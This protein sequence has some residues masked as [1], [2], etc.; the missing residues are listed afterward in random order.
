VAYPNSLVKGYLGATGQLTPEMRMKID[1]AVATGY[2]QLLTFEV[3]GGGFNWWVGSKSA[4]V[5]LTAYGVMEFADMERVLP[6]DRAVLDRASAFLFRTQA[7]DGTWDQVGENHG[8]RINHLPDPKTTLTAY[9]AWSLGESGY[10]GQPGTRRAVKFLE[11]RIADVKDTYALGLIVNALVANDSPEARR[12]VDELARRAKVEGETASWS[13]AATLSY[14]QGS[15]ADVETTALS[16]YALLRSKSQIE[17]ADKAVAWLIRQRNSH[18]GW[19]STQST[20]LA[21]KALIEQARQTGRG[22]GE[23][24]VSLKVNGKAVEGAFQKIT[25]KN[26]DVMQQVDV[27]DFVRPGEN[28]IEIVRDGSAR[29]SYQAAGRCYVPWRADDDRA[30]EKPVLSIDVRYDKERLLVTEKLAATVRLDYAAPKPTFMV[31]AEVGVPPG[32][33]A[34]AGSLD[35]LVEDG[36]IAR[37]STTARKATLY[38]GEVRPGRIEVGFELKPKYAVKVRTE[39]A[40]AYEYYTPERKAESKPQ[41]IEVAE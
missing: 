10:A 18:G 15:G 1:G 32:F 29:L 3:E 17:L 28:E 20:I 36:K 30:P 34:E 4:L 16:A 41:A 23:A 6:I 22:S 14:A 12:A 26:N 11:S 8:E 37:Y 7:A 27:T 24:T 40:T 5:W 9:V 39:P 35:R 21:I 33:S 13:G 38:F 25:A 31:I 19:G 2:Q